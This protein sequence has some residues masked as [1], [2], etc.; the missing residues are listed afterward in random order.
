MSTER[1]MEDPS[2]KEHSFI[3]STTTFLVAQCFLGIALQ[4]AVLYS[5][6]WST[7]PLT[8]L[9]LLFAVII[10]FL[11][12]VFTLLLLHTQHA[13]SWFTW[14]LTFLTWGLSTANLFLLTSQLFTSPE[15]IAAVSN[16]ALEHAND[17]TTCGGTSALALC[18]LVVGRNP[19]EWVASLYSD[20]RADTYPNLRSIYVIWVYSTV[21]FVALTTSQLRR[22]DHRVSTSTQYT[23][24]H[25]QSIAVPNGGFF[26]D[27][28]NNLYRWATHWTVFLAAFFMFLF[29]TLYYQAGML[30]QLSRMDVLDWDGWSFGQIAAVT[31]WVPVVVEY[32]HNLLLE[33]V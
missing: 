8:G 4:I 2:S 6:P 25:K 14:L 3:S 5:K 20:A 17:I 7:D 16:S 13:K 28:P 12:P 26:S 31:V 29:G 22:P 15:D 23:S 32:V 19:L 11:P 10:G 27:H 18:S 24:L 33:W 30:Y 1:V 21:T 9:G